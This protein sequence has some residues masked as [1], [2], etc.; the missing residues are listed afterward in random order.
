MCF[1]CKGRRFDLWLGT[2]IPQAMQCSQERKK[3]KMEPKKWQVLYFLD[4]ETIHL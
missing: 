3:E 2:K 1:H 4:R